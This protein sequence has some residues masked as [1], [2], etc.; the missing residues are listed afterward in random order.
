MTLLDLPTLV[1]ARFASLELS[2]APPSFL[3]SCSSPS[4]PASSLPLP[5]PPPANSL[6]HLRANRVV[7]L[8]ACFVSASYS[9]LSNDSF[10]FPTISSS[11]SSSTTRYLTPGLVVIFLDR[12]VPAQPHKP[13]DMPC[14][15]DGHGSRR[16][17]ALRLAWRARSQHARRAVPAAAS[18]GETNLGP[19]ADDR[20]KS[21]HDRPSL[22]WARRPGGQRSRCRPQRA[23]LLIC[24]HTLSS[25]IEDSLIEILLL[26]ISRISYCIDCR[27]ERAVQQ[28]VTTCSTLVRPRC[29]AGRR[30]W[31][32]DGRQPPCA[33]RGVPRN[34]ESTYQP[35]CSI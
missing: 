9:F 12:S 32:S 7:A 5:S 6:P 21:R 27:R 31:S 22:S 14:D 15:A 13:G 18:G 26:R 19:A 20:E 28:I 10:T 16:N 4:C 23:A 17:R 8:V 1:R 2:L 35:E 24:R 30:G 3:L 33:G 25:L 34:P 11:T 29:R